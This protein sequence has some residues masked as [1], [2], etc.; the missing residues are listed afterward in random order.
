MTNKKKTERIFTPVRNLTHYI[1]VMESHGDRVAFRY[2]NKNHELQEMTYGAYATLI[3]NE[4][5][6]FVK[7]GLAGKRIAVMGETSPFWVATYISAIVAGG[8]AIP[9]D[10]ELDMKEVEGFLL[11]AEADAVVYSSILNEKFADMALAHRGVATLIPME[12][13]GISY[14]EC[15]WVVPLGEVLTLGAQAREA[16]EVA[17]PQ[18]PENLER[19]AVMLF[20]SGT[21]GTSKCVMLCEKNVCAAANAACNTVE[22]SRD[23]VIVS[24]LPI[25]HTYELCIMLAASIYGM[26]VCIN[27]S[28][29]RVMKNI[30]FFKPTGMV[31]VP[32]FVTTMNKKIWE[33][34]RKKGQ[35][36][37]L[38]AAIRISKASR[39]VGID[40][41][42]KLFAEVRAAF[43][44]RLEKII[45]GAAPLNPEITEIFDQ[46]GIQICEGYGI[47][48]CSPLLSVTPYY[49]PKPGS[50]GKAV[51]CADVKIDVDHT[52]EAGH[53]VGEI[54]AKGDNVMLGYYKNPEETAKVFTEDGYFRTGDV[55]YIDKDGYIYI[56]GRKKFV[57][58]MES[59]KNVFPEEIEEYLSEIDLISECVVVGRKAP[60]SDEIILTAVV[61]PAFDLF[62]EEDR[63]DPEAMR[64]QIEARIQP[65]NKK[66]V[67]YKHIKAV[68]IRMEEFER[69]TSRKI[70]RHLVK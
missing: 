53:E 35:E 20:T 60:D 39:A 56:T 68:E 28:L 43:G 63:K 23:D 61:Y 38:R 19:M 44:G 41:R 7:M 21:T 55:G 36:K 8:V 10:R 67:S 16:G 29:K 45:S 1:D 14:A 52:D 37:K 24:V 6:G 4:V 62:S 17:E 57:I 33:E 58:V 13:E 9:M 5:A 50:V 3:R 30:A 40:L 51:D 48:E 34:A 69:T 64:K 18:E 49:A 54:L 70:K 65:L 31:L 27:D 32:L 22:F 42:K 46:F 66:L 26:Q 2:F 11:F 59:G 15:E 25:H 47:T 12:P